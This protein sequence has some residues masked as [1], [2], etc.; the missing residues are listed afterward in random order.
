MAIGLFCIVTM[1]PLTWFLRRRPPHMTPA[2]TGAG[3]G[4]LPPRQIDLSPR[5]LQ[6]LLAIAGLG[7]CVAMSMP[8][9]H[10]VAYCVDLGFGVARGAEM[11]SLML[12]GGIVSRLAVGLPGRL[13]RRGEDAAARLGAAVPGADGLHPLRRAGL[14]L[15]R[16]ARLRPVAGRHRAE[17]RD[18]RARIPAGARGRPARRLVI[19]ATIVGMA[20]GGWLSG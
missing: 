4:G 20:L 9:V 16:L 1:V 17:L 19:M 3:S 6:M 5:A 15:H 12:V 13:Y 11:L 2:A 18:H 14:A 8:Q 10:I 7:C